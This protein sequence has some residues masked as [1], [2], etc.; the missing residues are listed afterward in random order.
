MKNLV[1]FYIVY[2][3]IIVG[4]VMLVIGLVVILVVLR[5]GRL[6]DYIGF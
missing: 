5:L 4:V 1:G 2:I 6:L 3:E